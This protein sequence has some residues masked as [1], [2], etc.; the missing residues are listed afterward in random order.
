MNPFIFDPEGKFIAIDGFAR[1]ERKEKDRM[2]V[3]VMPKETLTPFFGPSGIAVVGI[4]THDNTKAGNIIVKNLL[5]LAREDVFCVNIKGG[6]VT[7]EG[8]KLHLYKSIMEINTSVDLA[9]ISVP[10]EVTIPV[11]EDC[12]KKGVK[13]IILIPGGF[14]EMGKNQAVE[15]KFWK[16]V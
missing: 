5:N 4:S 11:V 1:F 14:S 12:A 9:I 15:E 16:S 10:A 8:R 13:A 3:K 2:H 6:D 7:I